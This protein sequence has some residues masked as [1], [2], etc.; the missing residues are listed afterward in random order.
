M[1]LLLADGGPKP[2]SQ[3]SAPSQTKRKIT[4]TFAMLKF[5]KVT[6]DCKS[7]GQG[8]AGRANSLLNLV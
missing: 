5:S 7:F 6:Y 1:P 2:I 4:H 3:I 8:R